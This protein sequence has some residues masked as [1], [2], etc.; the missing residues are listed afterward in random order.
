MTAPDKQSIRGVLLLNE[1]MCKH[2]SW[3]VGGNAEQFYTPADLEDL[4][5]FLSALP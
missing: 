1:P 4:A 2:T 5:Q 3:R